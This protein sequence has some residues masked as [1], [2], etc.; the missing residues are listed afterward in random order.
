MDEKPF[1]FSL[2]TLLLL[3]AIVPLWVVCAF[4]ANPLKFRVEGVFFALC[5][6]AGIAWALYRLVEGHRYAWAIATVAAPVLAVGVLLLVAV[7]V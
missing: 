5:V 1:Q 2:S 3:M 6:S 4:I 7:M